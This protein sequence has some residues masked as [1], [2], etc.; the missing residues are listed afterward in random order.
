MSETGPNFA[1][2]ERTSQK[3]RYVMPITRRQFEL[4]INQHVEKLMRSAYDLLASHTEEAFDDDEIATV[5]GLDKNNPPQ[6]QAL[7]LALETLLHVLAI[8][9]RVVA[10]ARYYSHK[11]RIDTEAWERA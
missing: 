2:F 9:E 7:E 1:N 8:E 4:G 5:I 3:G 10:G 11:K 6:Q